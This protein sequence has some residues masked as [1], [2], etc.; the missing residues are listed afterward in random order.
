MTK[1]YRA[2]DVLTAAL[3]RVNRLFDEFDHVVINTSGG[4]DSTVV[5]NLTLQ[6]AEER[7][8]LPVPLMFLDQEAEW[9][10]VI[11]HVRLQM[12]DPRVKPYWLQIPFKLANATSE[13]MPFLHCWEEGGDWIRPKE[14]NSIKENIL[15][16]DRFAEI[17]NRFPEVYFPTGSVA[18]IGGVRAEESPARQAGLTSYP[19]YKDITWG[20]KIN[21]KRDV[22]TFYPI[23]DWTLSDVWKYIHDNNLPYCKLYDYMYQNGVP[24]QNMRVSN[25]HHETAV[26]MLT[27]LQELE[28]ETWDKISQRVSGVNAVNILGDHYGK[29]KDLPFMFASW[30][31]YRD[32]LLENLITDPERRETFRARFAHE[33]QRYSEE[34]AEELVKTQIGG[35]MVND[36]EGVKMTTFQAQHGKYAKGKGRNRN[37]YSRKYKP[38]ELPSGDHDYGDA[39]ASVVADSLRTGT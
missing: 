10:N 22:Y 28:P 36:Y 11:D 16:T 13:A 34:V 7:G 32:Y 26:I 3:R 38:G 15:G 4:K 24:I 6:V 20:R 31:E 9:S 8:R 14:P 12:S 29:P 33:D 30:H 1:I 17:F 23:Y 18:E 27:F 25:V 2:E 19:T 21:K 39:A 35:L 37:A 5:M